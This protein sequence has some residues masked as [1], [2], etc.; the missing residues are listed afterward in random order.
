MQKTLLE[1]Y[2]QQIIEELE[3]QM[4]SEITV[5][6]LLN[7]FI[8]VIHALHIL[9]SVM[10]L[11]CF[12]TH[13]IFNSGPLRVISNSSTNT[14]YGTSAGTASLTAAGGPTGTYS[15]TWIPSVSTSSQA[16]GL[17]ARSYSVSIADGSQRASQ[18]FVITQPA[19]TF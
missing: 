15:Y 6:Y 9:N 12:L 1:Y 10:P 14:C 18:D 7:L 4:L 19:G 8:Y 13:L 17:S 5:L 16:S 3:N 2:Q 11:Y